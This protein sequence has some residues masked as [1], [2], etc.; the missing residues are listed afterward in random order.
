M[1]RRSHLGNPVE[2][3]AGA[4][5]GTPDVGTVLER[6]LDQGRHGAIRGE[7]NGRGPG[8]GCRDGERGEEREHGSRHGSS[9]RAAQSTTSLSLR[10]RRNSPAGSRRMGPG[11][12]G[13]D[14]TIWITV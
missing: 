1:G 8:R 11:A 2:V 12:K 3:G 10:W 9:K 5:I 13:H 7:G 6:L 14:F 4:G